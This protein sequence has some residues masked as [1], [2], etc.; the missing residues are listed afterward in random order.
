MAMMRLCAVY[1]TTYAVSRQGSNLDTC[2]L[3]FMAQR[4]IDDLL[5]QNILIES[6]FTAG[7]PLV[8][9]SSGIPSCR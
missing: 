6:W 2:T 4:H 8:N 1:Y 9:K 5:K 7:R 3:L